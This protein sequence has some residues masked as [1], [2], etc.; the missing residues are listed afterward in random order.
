MLTN[1][2]VAYLLEQS[3]ITS[4][5]GTA[6]QPIPA[7]ADMSGYPCITYQMASDVPEYTLTG[8][9]G[10]STTRIVFDCLAPF[11]PGGYLI[12]R[13]MALAVKAALSGFEG[14]LPDG[15]K[16]FIAEVV[17]VTDNFDNDALLSRSTVHVSVVYSD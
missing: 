2:L 16:V 11:N 13:S 3:A 6:I 1:G 15:T 4:I 12:A 14:N 5:V 9:A 7:P 8:T 10:L 17:N